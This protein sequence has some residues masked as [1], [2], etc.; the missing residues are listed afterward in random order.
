MAVVLSN[1]DTFLNT[2]PLCLYA[3]SCEKDT[4]SMSTKHRV[5]RPIMIFGSTLSKLLRDETRILLKSVGIP[6]LFDHSTT[7]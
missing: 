1:G 3:V 7:S 4:L 5:R 6:N 2:I